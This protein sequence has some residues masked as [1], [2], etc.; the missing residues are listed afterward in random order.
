[1]LPYLC[2]YGQEGLRLLL[3]DI[4][5]TLGYGCNMGAGG[6]SEELALSCGQGV[7]FGVG[8]WFVVWC[9]FGFFLT[10]Q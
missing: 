6:L 7:I 3:G 4:S 2:G 10:P 1:M 5:P 9:V 8:S